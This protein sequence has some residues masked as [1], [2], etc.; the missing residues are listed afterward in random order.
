M[1]YLAWADA[2]I[3]DVMYI[4]SELMITFPL[5]LTKCQI[6][7]NFVCHLKEWSDRLITIT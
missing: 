5:G 7:S 1:M 2:S 4:I 6:I 3:L